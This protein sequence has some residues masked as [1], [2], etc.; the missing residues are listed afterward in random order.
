MLFCS[1]CVHGLT[2]QHFRFIS[3]Y[4]FHRRHATAAK[5]F[6]KAMYNW[7]P[8]AFPKE[9]IGVMTWQMWQMKDASEC[10]LSG[11]PEC[12]FAA[13]T[14]R[15]FGVVSPKHTFLSDAKIS[16]YLQPYFCGQDERCM[17]YGNAWSLAKAKENVDRWFPLVGIME[18]MEETLALA[19]TLM[20][21]FFDGARRELDA[22]SG[23]KRCH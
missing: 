8:A 5:I 10:V 18:R 17:Q 20:P 4:D 2:L 1:K 22:N 15:D 9:T 11:D 23:E 21:R 12:N 19:E 3:R 6:F 14:R 7:E 16:A 13:G